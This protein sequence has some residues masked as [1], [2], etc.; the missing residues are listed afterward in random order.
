MVPALVTPPDNVPGAPVATPIA[1]GCLFETGRSEFDF[2]SE[3]DMDEFRRLYCARA[4][5]NVAISG[6]ARLNLSKSPNDGKIPLVGS[7]LSPPNLVNQPGFV[8]AGIAVRKSP[9]NTNCDPLLQ[10]LSSVH[11]VTTWPGSLCELIC[12]TAW[13]TTSVGSFCEFCP[14][15]KGGPSCNFTPTIP[16]GEL[17]EQ[18]YAIDVFRLGMPNFGGVA[19]DD[20]VFSDASTVGARI[21][22]GNTDTNCAAKDPPPTTGLVTTLV[23]LDGA[24]VEKVLSLALGDFRGAGAFAAYY[25]AVLFSGSHQIRRLRWDGAN[26]VDEVFVDTLPPNNTAHSLEFD[27]FTTFSGAEA[28]SGDLFVSE[29]GSLARIWRINENGQVSDFGSGFR[30]PNG[31]AFHPAGVMLVSDDPNP[32]GTGDANVL[33]LDGWRSMFNRGDGNAD[34]TIDISDVIFIMNWA[35]GSEPIVE[36]SCLDAAD[37]NH[38]STIDISD[39]I[40]VSN[41]LFIDGPPPDPP[42]RGIDP[43]DWCPGAEINSEGADATVDPTVDLLGCISY[44]NCTVNF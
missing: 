14:E 24:G 41:F 18:P 23:D 30:D 21:R 31:M 37:A 39:G 27:E 38:D 42:F 6:A 36:P 33:V 16:A 10:G 15:L 34:G 4:T 12:R 1:P 20:V 11:V 8:A 22:C 43:G 40:Y 44:R 35:T 32:T 13:T 17:I 25:V 29:E 2:P 3:F 7:E 26:Y 19:V 9:A 28:G 5:P